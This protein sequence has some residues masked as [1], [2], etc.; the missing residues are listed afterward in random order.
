MRCAAVDLE[1]EQGRREYNLRFRE[2]NRVYLEINVGNRTKKN[3]PHLKLK[4]KG[5]V[6][7]RQ[8]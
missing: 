2:Y 1:G 5:G 3:S 4:V 8:E 7:K 6:I